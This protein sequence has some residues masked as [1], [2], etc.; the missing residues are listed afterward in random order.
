[1]GRSGIP[2]LASLG[3]AGA[4]AVAVLYT[5]S[6]PR[7]EQRTPVETQEAATLGR[8]LA[9]L[10]ERLRRLE[11]R[12]LAAPERSP[13]APSPPVA[14]GTRDPRGAELEALR[15]RVDALEKSVAGLREMWLRGGAARLFA[16]LLPPG[17][18]AA[19]NK[20]VLKALGYPY[21]GES[22][23]PRDARIALNER[24]LREF[25][26]DPDSAKHLRDLF[27][28]LVGRSEER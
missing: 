17:A 27:Q 1:M 9:D 20:Q 2:W 5:L 3:A 16:D 14:E 13:L 4:I 19:E 24:L 26:E 7:E 25:P 8:R 23:P 11:D 6:S 18:S 10:E 22:N 15:V 21:P 28:D 12:P